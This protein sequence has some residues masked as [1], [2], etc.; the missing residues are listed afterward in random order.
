[1]GAQP[2]FATATSTR[3]T[4]TAMQINGRSSSNDRNMSRET[5]K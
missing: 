2:N 3:S 4:T 1:M 5:G